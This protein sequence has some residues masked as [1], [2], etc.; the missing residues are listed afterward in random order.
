MTRPGHQERSL[1][2]GLDLE[3]DMTGKETWVLWL[4]E[5]EPCVEWM[6]LLESLQSTSRLKNKMCQNVFFKNLLLCV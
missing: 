3:I 4:S 2:C 1:D 6:N 5:C